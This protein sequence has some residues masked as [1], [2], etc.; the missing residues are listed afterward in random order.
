MRRY[1]VKSIRHSRACVCCSDNGTGK[2][3]VLTKGAAEIILPLCS[4]QMRPDGRT[5]Q[6]S[7]QDA[8]GILDYLSVDSNRCAPTCR[9]SGPLYWL[10]ASETRQ[11]TEVESRCTRCTKQPSE[12]D[13]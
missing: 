12:Q 4:H 9:Q 1:T 3:M 2:A 8:Q 7:E 5:K 13:V 6:L 10:L 11:R